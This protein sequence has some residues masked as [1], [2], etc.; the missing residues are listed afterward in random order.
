[1]VKNRI[2]R[3]GMTIALA[4]AMTLSALTI[5]PPAHAQWFE[6]TYPGF[7][8][9]RTPGLLQATAFGGGFVSDKYGVLQEGTQ[10][11][12]S[13]T[14][15]IGVFGRAT[16]YQL[17]I[18]G[19]FE[20]PLAPGSGSFPRLNFG[21]FQGGV[22]LALYQGTHLYVSAGHDVADSDATVVEGDFSSWIFL[23][24]Q[25]PV[26]VSF[27]SVHDFQNGVTST[28]IDLETI[29]LSREKYMILA[30]VGG[31]MYNGGFLTDAQGEGGPDLGF[32]YRPWQLGVSAQAG[33][34]NAHQYGQISMYKQI[35]WFE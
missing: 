5:A 1:V 15:Y 23:H 4:F 14:P 32:Y 12:Q 31:A 20:S 19:G 11:E 22:D 35:S 18:G 24:S 21:R 33:Y 25:H 27:S 7:F 17:W 28:E 2:S 13:V 16:G 8:S 6:D 34:G 3:L 9:L 30:G 10:I 29:V 26:N